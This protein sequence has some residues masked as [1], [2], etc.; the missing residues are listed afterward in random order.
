MALALPTGASQAVAVD[1]SGAQIS[2]EFAMHA[3]NRDVN[4]LLVYTKVKLDSNDSVEVNSGEGFGFNGFE[5]MALGKAS[6]GST[7]QNSL[8]RDHNEGTDVHYQTNAQFRKY[9]Q[10]RFDSLKLF[11]FLNDDGM[12]V[13]R[14][15]NDYTYATGENATSTTGSN[16]TPSGGSYYTDSN[17]N[18]YL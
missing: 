6:D 12:L 15:Q 16:W 18:R 13:A 8:Q 7:D 17:I 9:Q 11:Y 4:G 5:G 14:Y 2:N 3:L 10:S 1:A